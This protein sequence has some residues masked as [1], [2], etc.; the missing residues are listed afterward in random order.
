MPAQSATPYW[1]L[2]FPSHHGTYNWQSPIPSHMGNLNLQPSIERHYDAAGLFNQNIL[3][4]GK[5]EQ[6]PSFY[7]WTPYTKQPPTTILPKQRGNKNK[8]N[9]KKDNLSQLNLGNPFDDENEGGDDVI[10]L[11]GQLTGNY[12]VYENMDPEKF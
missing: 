10:F 2:A 6:R 9:V 3:N 8:N 1:Q 7:K 5:G 11:G 12:L 4:R